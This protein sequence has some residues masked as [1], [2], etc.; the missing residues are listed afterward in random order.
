M[1]YLS[2]GWVEGGVNP[3]ENR[4]KFRLDSTGHYSVQHSFTRRAGGGRPAAGVI[5]DSAGNL[6]GTAFDGK[7]QN[8]IVYRLGSDGYQVLYSFTNGA[9]GGLPSSGVIRDSAGNLYGTTQFGGAGGQGVVYKL[10]P[11]GD[12]TVLYSFTGGAD[13]GQPFGGVI[14][15]SAGNLYGTASNGGVGG[16]KACQLDFIG[17]GVVYKIDT[18]GHYQVL[19][20]FTGTADGGAPYIR[21]TL[22]PAGNLFGATFAGGSHRD[23]VVYHL[24]GISAP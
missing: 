9:D 8:G 16:Q 11:V 19:Y 24:Q 23:G 18:A 2:P 21:P 6:Y 4:G 20:S 12:Y 10:G 5:G 22:D 3:S 14:Q 15:D 1:A 7:Y 13:G 17:C